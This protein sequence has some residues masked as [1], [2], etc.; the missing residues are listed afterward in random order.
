MRASRVDCPSGTTLLGCDLAVTM[1]NACPKVSIL[2]AVYNEERYIDEMIASVQAQDLREWEILFADDGSTDN[3]VEVIRLCSRVDPRIKLISYGEK[4]GKVR[5]FN[6]AYA[7]SMGQIIVL[8]AG[9]DR[10]P[11]NSLKVR[12]ESV[13]A[14]PSIAPGVGFFKIRMF[15]DQQRFNGMVLPRGKNSS[16]TGGSIT[17]NRALAG[18]LFPIDESLVSEDIWLAY[19]SVDIA[20][21]KVEHHDVVLDYRIHDG[22]SNPRHKP[23]AA[24]T[25]SLHRRHRAWQALLECPRF[26]LSPATVTRLTRLWAAEQHRYRGDTLA[27]LRAPLPPIERVAMASSSSRILFVARTRG[28]KFFS[29]R[30]R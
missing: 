28:Y 30:R 13:S 1:A 26:T 17:M 11:C 3:T 20:C 6:R 7:A 16:R 19:G 14:L 4:L 5:A 21:S 24:M 18:I 10:L 25:E 12:Y 23:F 8:L 9:D 29:G 27:L 15:S 22:N 2:S